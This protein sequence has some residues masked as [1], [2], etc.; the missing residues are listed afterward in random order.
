MHARYIFRMD[1]ITPTMHW[2][3]F[4]SMLGLLNRYRVKPLLGI[5]PDNRDPRLNCQQPDPQ[6]WDTMRTLSSKG[7]VDI[8]QH[9]YQHALTVHNGSPLLKSTHGRTVARSEFTGYSYNEQ[10]SRIQRGRA[11]M[12]ENGLETNFW[13]APNHSFDHTTIRALRVAGFSA[14]SDGISL[15]PY[16]HL[17]MLFVPQQLWRPRWMPAG[18]FTIC[19]HTNDMSTNHI[20]SIR[21]FLR[22]PTTFSSFSA[23][24]ASFPSKGPSRVCNPIFKGFYRGARGA[25]ESLDWCR[26]TLKGGPL[27]SFASD[28]R[29]H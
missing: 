27:S 19:L 28:G 15:F 29:Q 24:V 22:T 14:I 5:V 16:E 9:G 11:I 4:W 12:R 13:F 21:R 3:R 18:V 10:L 1:D 25:K 26:T 2:G 6:F 20:K 17:G 23:E 8:A 7:L